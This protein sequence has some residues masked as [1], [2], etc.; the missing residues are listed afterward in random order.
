[1]TEK[2]ENWTAYDEWLVKNYK[3]YE[4]IAVNEQEDKSIVAEF[5]T[6]EEFQQKYG[7][8]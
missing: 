4:I 1:M 3:E 7:S 2:F 8:H 6:K 5:I